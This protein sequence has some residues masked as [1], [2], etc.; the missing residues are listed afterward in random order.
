MGRGS[1]E[2]LHAC[3]L[4]GGKGERFWPL[5]RESRPKQLANVTGNGSMIRLT[6][7]RLIGEIPPE[8]ILVVTSAL[9]AD[10]VAQEL[11]FIPRKQIIGE[12]IGRNSAPAIALAAAWFARVDPDAVFLVAPS[13]H[14]LD[15]S[16]F[17]EALREAVGHATATQDLI[18]FG[19]SP[20]RP[21]T[22]YGY[23]ERGECLS[24]NLYR[25][26]SFTEKPDLGKATRFVS[27]GRHL[28][29]SGMF[30]WGAS[31]ILA[32]I[33]RHQPEI[34]RAVR[35]LEFDEEGG[36]S[37]DALEA[38]YAACPAISID[39]AVMERDSH[40]AVLQSGFRW[41]DMGSWASLPEIL[42]ADPDHNVSVGEVRTLGC[43]NS[44]FYSD[45]API[46]AVG[47]EGLVV[48][49]VDEMTLVCPKN[50]VQEIKAFVR[51]MQES[52]SWRRYL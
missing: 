17:L 31:A 24:G 18:M 8:R 34:W 30:V 16:G 52:E 12:P 13:D 37:P 6:V 41:S 10:R 45:G 38:F 33:E 26:A 14:V 48:V 25:A 40:V 2:L 23:I 39:Y 50:R 7:E 28:W 42:E 15:R 5:S 36:V 35:A 49:R 43:R 47:V 44:V 32:A 11:V 3:V 51:L 9:L 19:I 20:S 4:A 21:E 27:E 46:A 29:N 1:L 22:G